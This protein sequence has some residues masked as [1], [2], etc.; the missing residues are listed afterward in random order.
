MNLFVNGAGELDNTG[1]LYTN[2]AEHLQRINHIP[3]QTVLI[4]GGI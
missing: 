3:K 4:L 1:F 2:F